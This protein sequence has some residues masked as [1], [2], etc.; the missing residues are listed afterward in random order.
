MKYPSGSFV[1][2]SN[3][4]R[5]YLSHYS[6]TVVS[7]IEEYS[8]GVY[9][10]QGYDKKQF[11][12]P[13]SYFEDDSFLGYGNSKICECGADKVYGEGVPGFYHA[14]YCPKYSSPKEID[15]EKRKLFIN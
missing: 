14:Q 7:I 10:V 5:D 1:K 2:L 6:G 11:V 4:Y 9:N 8:K 3:K 12:C 15:E 13:E